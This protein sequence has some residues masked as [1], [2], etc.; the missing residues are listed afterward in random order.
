MQKIPKAVLGHLSAS[1][2]RVTT[3]KMALRLVLLVQ[4]GHLITLR[5]PQLVAAAMDIMV[6][7][8]ETYRVMRA[9]P[10]PILGIKS[11]IQTIGVTVILFTTQK[12][13]VTANQG[14]SDR[15]QKHFLW[16]LSK[17]VVRA[18]GLRR[19]SI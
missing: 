12:S 11:I 14:T 2:T 1:A 3:P 16:I 19:S 6:R 17:P 13:H 18:G 5:V 8:V 15:I 9:L 4:P 7:K 10:T